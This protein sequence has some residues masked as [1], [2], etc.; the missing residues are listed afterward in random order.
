MSKEL[1]VNIF[2][3]AKKPERLIELQVFNNQVN[4]VHYHYQ[5]P[6]FANGKWYVWFFADIENYI[7]PESLDEK[8]IK[9]AKGEL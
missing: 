5:T 2:L 9:L 3:S 1:N 4:N 6:V 8:S 7:H